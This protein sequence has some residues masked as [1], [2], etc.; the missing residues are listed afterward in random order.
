M[1]IGGV[2]CCHLVQ[3]N[4]TSETFSHALI[5]GRSS[6]W[7][8]WCPNKWF[9]QLCQGFGQNIQEH[10]QVLALPQHGGLPHNVCYAKIVALQL[11]NYQRLCLNGR[12][13]RQSVF[14]RVLLTFFVTL[15]L[16]LV[17]PHVLFVTLHVWFVGIYHVPRDIA[18]ITV[19]YHTE[20]DK[21]IIE[22]ELIE[23][24]NYGI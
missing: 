15:H 20:V 7:S 4:S 17:T 5:C 6:T 16:F 1:L 8:R 22:V 9:W 10:A 18:V 19:R 21:L 3:P 2:V 14:S 24:E 12:F 23:L 11:A 13:M